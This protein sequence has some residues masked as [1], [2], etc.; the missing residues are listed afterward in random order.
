MTRTS[1]P[2]WRRVRCVVEVSLPNTVSE[3]DLRNYVQ[4]VIDGHGA[5]YESSGG[6]L[7]AK[8]FSAVLATMKDNRPAKLRAVT[9][10]LEAAIA[11][12]KKL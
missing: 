10:S 2:K 3:R 7:W 8:Q 1:K 11:R 6:R 12:L 9:K 5:Y 4:S